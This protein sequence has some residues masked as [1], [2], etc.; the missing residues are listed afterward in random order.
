M[1][2]FLVFL[3]DEPDKEFI[4]LQMGQFN[5]LKSQ[6]MINGLLGQ[7]GFEVYGLE[8][9]YSKDLTQIFPNKK[10][11]MRLAILDPAQYGD[12]DILP[13][14]PEYE[15]QIIEEVFKLYMQQPTAGK[16][17]DATVKEDKSFPVNTQKQSG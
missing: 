1:G 14:P 10:V 4:P 2:V 13:L 7:I 15:T 11:A 17:V 8:V 3:M 9:I 6:R 12:Y 16:I 5:L